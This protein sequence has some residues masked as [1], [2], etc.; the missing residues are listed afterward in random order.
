MEGPK[1]SAYK[2]SSS[3]SSCCPSATTS[4]LSTRKPR[5]TGNTIELPVTAIRLSLRTAIG[6]LFRISKLVKDFN[7]EP[8]EKKPSPFHVE[9]VPQHLVVVLE[10]EVQVI[11]QSVS[12]EYILFPRI[13]LLFPISGCVGCGNAS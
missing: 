7:L 12:D 5:A 4:D 8:V 2:C 6:W 13:T 9:A 3:D 11:N 1:A 10:I